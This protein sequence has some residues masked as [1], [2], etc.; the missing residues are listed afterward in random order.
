[1]A[2]WWDSLARGICVISSKLA[3][4]VLKHC[5]GKN[6]PL[7]SPLCHLIG[8]YKL[9]LSEPLRDR[10]TGA[11]TATARAECLCNPQS[12]S[13][14]L[15]CWKQIFSFGTTYSCFREVQDSPRCCSP[16]EKTYIHCHVGQAFCKAHRPECDY[17]SR[18]NPCCQS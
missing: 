11:M 5:W 6:G 16:E 14:R 15:T 1:M 10:S 17:V 2:S 9:V 7:L 13:A 3:Q 4:P 8:T 18:V 12:L